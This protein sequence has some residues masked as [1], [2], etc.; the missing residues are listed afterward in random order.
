MRRQG[1]CVHKQNKQ[2]LTNKQTT[3]IE[4]KKESRIILI[5][6]PVSFYTRLGHVPL[7]V[8]LFCFDLVFFT[9]T[10]LTDPFFESPSLF[11]LILGVHCI[12]IIA[13]IWVHPL[14]ICPKFNI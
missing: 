7:V 12:A 5:P 3:S 2:H 6:L 1:P 8:T 9:S 4:K 10:T 11:A 13:L 14:R